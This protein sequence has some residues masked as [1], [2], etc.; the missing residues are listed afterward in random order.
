MNL[1]NKGVSL[2]GRNTEKLTLQL[3]KISAKPHDV[4]LWN[5]KEYQLAS[6]AVNWA[7]ETGQY[8]IMEL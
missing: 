1:V 2:Y 3:D 8:I 7:E 4:I 6:E 5:R